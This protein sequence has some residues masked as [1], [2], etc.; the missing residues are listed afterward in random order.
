MCTK[1]EDG[2]FVGGGLHGTIGDVID[3][4]GEAGQTGWGRVQL[5]Q[6][7]AKRST[8]LLGEGGRR[9]GRKGACS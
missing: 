1:K 8:K 6:G 7:M 2:V 4:Q 3:L 9:A 5:S